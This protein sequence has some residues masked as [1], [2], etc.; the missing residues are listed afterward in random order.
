MSTPPIQ[1]RRATVDDLA[2][3][4]PL[5][6]EE[7][8]PVQDL[9]RRF[10]EFQVAEEGG[11]ILGAIGLQVSGQEARLHSEVFVH[12][13]QA[14][15]LREKLW[16][17]VQILADNH[18]TVRVWTQLTAPYW[19][20]NV[21][22][23]APAELIEKLPPA[24]AGEAHPWL[25]IQ[26]RSEAAAVSIDKEFAMFREAERERTERMFRQARVLKMVAAVFAAGVLFLVLFW[27]LSFF[28]LRN[29]I[30]K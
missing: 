5:W 13:E 15:A 8:L 3:L 12:P 17:R 4:V 25:F 2:K 10:K 23:P 6:R 28:R 14:D 27:A 7:G 19:R 9:E 24:F 1:V 29:R 21:F 26:L 11:E 18:G 22:A 30:Q 20:Q 16:E